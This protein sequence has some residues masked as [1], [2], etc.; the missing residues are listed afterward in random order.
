M[1]VLVLG[2]PRTGTQSIA[3]ALGQMGISP[4]YHMRDVVRNK[5][6]DLWIQAIED[7]FERG[8]KSWTREDFDRILV[9]FEG[10]SDYPAT[11]FPAELIDAYPEARIILST[12]SEDAWFVSIMSTLWHLHCNRP[13][14]D[15]SP[16]AALARKYNCH[17]WDNDFPANGRILFRKHNELVRQSSKGRKFLEYEVKDGWGPLCE[18]LGIDIPGTPFPRSDDWVEY[19]RMVGREK[20]LA[21]LNTSLIALSD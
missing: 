12:R 10:V 3:D 21:S 1:R 15:S 14:D 7:K 8:G 4:V 18:F 9:G 20:E 6:Q 19:K 17:C 5:H 13:S 11:I 2:L 16:M